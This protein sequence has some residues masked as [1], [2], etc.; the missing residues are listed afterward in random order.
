VRYLLDV[1][2]WVAVLDEAHVFHSAAL[3]FV[4]QLNVKI[5]TCPLV[6]NGVLRVLNLPAYGK[7][8]AVGFTAVRN[9]LTE[10][11]AALDHE[12]WSDEVSLLPDNVVQWPRVIGHNQI[13]D[14]YLLALAVARGGCLVTLDRRVALVTVIGA[15]KHHLKD[16]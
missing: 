12:F 9:K 16:L 13:T 15:E 3:A 8:G 11:C 6:E 7:Y 4:E 5:A 10:I 2:I 1:N 14:V